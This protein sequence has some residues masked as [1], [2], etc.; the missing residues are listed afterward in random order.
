MLR[1]ALLV[2]PNGKTTKVREKI[3]ATGQ[4]QNV[5]ML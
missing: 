1:T 5:L 3:H 4:A 2:D